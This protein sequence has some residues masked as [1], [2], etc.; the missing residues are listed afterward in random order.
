[1]DE[2]YGNCEEGETMIHLK[3]CIGQCICCERLILPKESYYNNS[4]GEMVM[5]LKCMANFE[6][7][8]KAR[9]VKP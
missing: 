2:R 4:E 7:E 3:D 5:C 1:M 8:G 9:K 6:L